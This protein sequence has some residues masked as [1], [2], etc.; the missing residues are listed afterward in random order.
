[1]K[2]RGKAIIYGDD[3]DTDIIIPGRYLV[4]QDP[5]EL[6]KHA[7]EGMFCKLLGIL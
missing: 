2:I 7:M 5:K 4:L 3:I 6:A 1:M